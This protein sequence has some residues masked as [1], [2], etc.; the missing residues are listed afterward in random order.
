MDHFQNKVNLSAD[1]NIRVTLPF[2]TPNFFI[3]IFTQCSPSLFPGWL[4]KAADVL[5][6][7]LPWLPRLC[8]LKVLCPFLCHGAPDMSPHS[9]GSSPAT[10]PANQTPPCDQL[11]H[12]GRG[13]QK[14]SLCTLAE[15]DTPLLCSCSWLAGFVQFLGSSALQTSWVYHMGRGFIKVLNSHGSAALLGS[16]FCPAPLRRP[17]ARGQEESVKSTSTITS[18]LHL[19]VIFLTCALSGA[20]RFSNGWFS[21]SSYLW[22]GTSVF[23]KHQMLP[24]AFQ[25]PS[26]LLISNA[27]RR[28]GLLCFL[29]QR[30]HAVTSE[31]GHKWCA[32]NFTP[33]HLGKDWKNWMSASQYKGKVAWEQTVLVA[34]SC[35]AL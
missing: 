10:G 12:T 15:V 18:S 35:K 28:L 23:T 14:C 26:P 17:G 25:G 20:C 6:L 19:S 7:S 9:C 1:W 34:F 24:S 29:C 2:L 5:R 21:F 27:G 31:C 3:Y 30:V 16:G 13:N 8:F 11:G 33:C 22:S 4:E 32:T